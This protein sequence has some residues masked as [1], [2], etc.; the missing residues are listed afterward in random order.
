LGRGGG[1][2]GIKGRNGEEKE[3]K[4][5][6]INMQ[7]KD[8]F[9]LEQRYFSGEKKINLCWS[10]TNRPNTT[11]AIYIAHCVFLAQKNSNG[12]IIYTLTK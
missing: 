11:C 4:K 10:L 1:Q 3:K 7:V 12:S 5:R 8:F 6:A 9:Y 2:E